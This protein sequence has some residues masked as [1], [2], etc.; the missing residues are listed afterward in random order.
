MTDK[1]D[2]GEEAMVYRYLLSKEES[3][4]AEPE[5]RT[6]VDLRDAHER[7]AAQEC[8]D[9]TC[10]NRLQCDLKHCACGTCP[11]TES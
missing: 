9:C 10:C 6:D 7:H 8:P 4:L 1:F 2:S 3:D 5:N 11:C